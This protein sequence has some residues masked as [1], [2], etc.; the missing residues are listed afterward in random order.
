MVIYWNLV[1]G[2]FKNANSKKRG[3]PVVGVQNVSTYM[4]YNDAGKF[5]LKNMGAIIHPYL[6]RFFLISVLLFLG[7]CRNHTHV[8]SLK[9]SIDDR[10]PNTATS[11]FILVRWMGATAL[12]FLFRRIS[13]HFEHEFLAKSIKYYLA[14][15]KW[16]NQ[17]SVMR[18]CM[19]SNHC[20]HMCAQTSTHSTH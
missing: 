11:S 7:G 17:Q 8:Q 19:N 15:I 6:E 13:T 2:I 3:Y 12:G 14:T 9:K 16:W 4:A 10:S 5:W 1:C 18:E 20:T